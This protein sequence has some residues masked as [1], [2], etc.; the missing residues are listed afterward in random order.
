MTVFLSFQTLNPFSDN[1]FV[2]I[3]LLGL[4][5]EFKI[6]WSVKA[7]HDE[8]SVGGVSPLGADDAGGHGT[9]LLEEHSP[10]RLDAPP[11]GPGPEENL[12]ERQV[13][14]VLEPGVNVRRIGR[15][16]SN[17]LLLVHFGT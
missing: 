2:F 11:I 8:V 5:H 13:C 4:I 10:P 12:L 17:N 9:L 16:G 1:V 15:L 14:R 3:L 6:I 7:W